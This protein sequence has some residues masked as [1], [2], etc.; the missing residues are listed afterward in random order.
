MYSIFNETYKI[1]RREIEDE[2][3]AG[4]Y[5]CVIEVGCGTGDIIGELN[6]NVPCYGLDINTSFLEFCRDNHPH[7]HCEFLYGDATD[8]VPWF[9]SFNG[10]YKKPLVTCV[11]NTLP[12][13]PESIR[14]KVVAEMLAISGEQGRCLVTYWNGN[15][16]S[17]AVMNYYQTNQ[18][19]CGQFDMQKHINWDTRTLVTPSNYSTTWLLTHEVQSMLRAC[20]I[21]VTHQG[22]RHLY[23]QDHIHTQG[24]A[25]FVWFTQASTSRAKA[26]YDS[27]DAQKFYTRYV[28]LFAT[29]GKTHTQQN[30]TGRLT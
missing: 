8:L 25:I 11:N 28:C 24:L 4:G 10:K 30:L 3:K 7:D 15:F 29:M 20:D 18:E 9:A 14:G 12:I 2:V 13:M 16:F 26:Y 23:D 6:V 5:D 1:T 21:D 27:D 17:H 19:L 22:D